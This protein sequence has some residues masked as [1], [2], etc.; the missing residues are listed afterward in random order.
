[1]METQKVG[2]SCLGN[3]G[4][5]A[6]MFLVPKPGKPALDLQE[7]EVNCECFQGFLVFEICCNGTDFSPVFSGLFGVTRSGV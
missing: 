7:D 1:M 5:A 2:W 4:A 6:G 3:V